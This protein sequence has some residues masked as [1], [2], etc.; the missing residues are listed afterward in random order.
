MPP[1]LYFGIHLIGGE[2]LTPMLLVRRFTLN[3]VLVIL[4][5]VFWFGMWSV[6]GAISCPHARHREDRLRS[7]APV[8]A[9]RALPRRV[10]ATCPSRP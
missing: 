2:A 10:K 7:S 3:P 4:A 5:L 1:A 9:A 6:P 8:K